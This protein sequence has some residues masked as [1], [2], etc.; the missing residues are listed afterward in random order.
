MVDTDTTVVPGGISP[1]VSVTNCPG[2]TRGLIAPKVIVVVELVDPVAVKTPIGDK[3][4]PLMSP[5]NTGVSTVLSIFA[6]F[7]PG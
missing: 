2:P 3:D 1:P 7:C 6:K 5:P 4:V